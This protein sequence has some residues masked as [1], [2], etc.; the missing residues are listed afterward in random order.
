M[1][2]GTKVLIN[3]LVSSVSDDDDDNT[4]SPQDFSSG[5][6][7]KPE[8]K[9]CRVSAPRAGGGEGGVEVDSFL[10]KFKS[11]MERDGFMK[12]VELHTMPEGV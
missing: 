7:Y 8:G 2:P 11:E 5:R 9:F 10:L 4:T 1:G 12:T 3:V 6:V